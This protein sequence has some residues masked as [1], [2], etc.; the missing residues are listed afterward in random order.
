MKT[1]FLLCSIFCL[2]LNLNLSAEDVEIY[3]DNIKILDDNNIIKSTNTK[4][5]IKEKKLFLEGKSSI[6]DKSKQEITL[7]GDTI[8]I[9]QLKNLKINAEEA[10]YDKKIDTLITKGITKINIEDKYE[11]LSK[12]MYY[13]RTSQNI[14]S[15]SYTHLTLPTNA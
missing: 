10:I 13:D 3:S 12:N 5:S 9:D 1:K 4:A 2:L 15:V 14:F 6:Y 7:T 11:I 8:F